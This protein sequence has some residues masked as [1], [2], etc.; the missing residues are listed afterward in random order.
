MKKFSV[1]VA[2]MMSITFC[3]YSQEIVREGNTFSAAKTAR[4]KEEPL[5]TKYIWKDAKNVEYQIFVTKGTGACFVNKTSSKT[6]N[7]YRYYL[8]EAISKE[9]CKELGIEYKGKTTK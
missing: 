5:A 7:T 3:G 2:L 8:G 9:I 6:G 1:L 4:T